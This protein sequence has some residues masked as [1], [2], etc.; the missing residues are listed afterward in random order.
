VNV[1]TLLIRLKKELRVTDNAD[2]VQL[3]NMLI[4]AIDALQLFKC[5]T[6]VDTVTDPATETILGPLD[7][8][9][10]FVYCAMTY[11]GDPKLQTALDNLLLLTR[12]K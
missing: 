11:D 5:K 2:D 8:R 1:K 10:L 9:F 12:T 7:E 3:T 6:I 4:E